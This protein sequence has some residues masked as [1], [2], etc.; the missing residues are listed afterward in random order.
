M[1][2]ARQPTGAPPGEPDADELRNAQDIATIRGLRAGELDPNL[3]WSDLIGR[4]RRR[5][6]SLAYRFTGRY[7][8]AE[9][10][11]QEIIV[12]VFHQLDRFDPRAHFAVW[13]NSVA[14][15]HCIDRYRT[16]TR[17]RQRLLPEEPRFERMLDASA[18]HPDRILERR[19]ARDDLKSALARLSPKLREVLQLRFFEEL[20]YEEICDRLGV[21]EG[22]VKSRIHRGRAELKRHLA[23]V[24]KARR[25]P[26]KP[27]FPQAR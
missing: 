20:A 21:P 19:E 23:S 27:P 9:E 25:R 7:E 1:A 24:R 15:N 4:H 12:R 22:T 10:L 5:L 2:A 13:L 14:R 3:A 18:P 17:E 11:T 6:F 8:E 26:A 16:R